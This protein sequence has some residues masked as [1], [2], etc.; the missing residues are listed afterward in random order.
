MTDMP[1]DDDILTISTAELRKNTYTDLVY[2]ILILVSAAILSAVIAISDVVFFY[3]VILV[4][5]IGWMAMNSLAPELIILN[6]ASKSIVVR[7]SLFDRWMLAYRTF[8]LASFYA[9]RLRSVDGTNEN[10][11]VELVGKYGTALTLFKS[12]DVDEARDF[13]SMIAKWMG[14][15]VLRDPANPHLT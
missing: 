12:S 1:T 11:L 13:R 5:V 8:P 14:I 7:R 10:F 15:Q 4:L 6:K 3:R 9:V 2:D